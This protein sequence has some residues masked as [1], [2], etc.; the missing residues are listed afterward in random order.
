MVHVVL[1]FPKHKMPYASSNPLITSHSQ[2][3]IDLPVTAQE[4]NSKFIISN[5]FK[6]TNL[7]HFEFPKRRFL[8][9]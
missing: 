4:Q 5:Y 6:A 3:D 8:F 9:V 1:H 2:I 7:G